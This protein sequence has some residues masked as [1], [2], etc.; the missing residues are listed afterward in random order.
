MRLKLTRANMTR[1]GLLFAVW[2]VY[3]FLSAWQ[4][5]YWYSFSKTPMSWAE[6]LRFEMG[7]GYLWCLCSPFI[8]WLAN[9]FRIDR[10]HLAGHLALHLAAATGFIAISKTAFD[11]LFSPPN[12]AFTH[13]TWSALFRSI[14]STADTGAL[15]YFVIILIEHA[16]VYYKRYRDG[17]VDASRLQTQLAKA[18]LQ[19]LK[20]Q[21][22]P[23]FLFN[24]LH[25]ITALVHEDPD[26]AER[27][28]S[29]LSELLRLFLATSMIHEV[30]LAE[31]LRIL[32]LYIDIERTRFEDRLRVQE[33][34]PL[35][36]LDAMVPN[37][38]LQP[39]VENSIRHGLARRAEPGRISI[40]AE[41][42]GD[43]L[44]LRVADNGTGLQPDALKKQPA[45]MGLAITRNRLKTLYGTSQSLSLRN[46]E[47]GG[48]EARITIPFRTC[49]EI[50]EERPH[51]A[52]QSI[53]R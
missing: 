52:L 53:D 18:Q 27:T 35:E 8:L 3:G 43:T 12:S 31:E 16:S 9:R 45:G 50:P 34:V 48:V 13:F 33:D 30:P 38:V 1:A 4:T 23:H 36:L 32:G 10:D 47:T 20:M 40:S 29:R 5:H 46:L 25:T 26:L 7:Y 11:A 14:E 2:T 17:M 44:V 22:H 24:T 41:K 15:L 39:L 49:V 42:S 37:L 21:L 19:A 6:S 28:I 51:A